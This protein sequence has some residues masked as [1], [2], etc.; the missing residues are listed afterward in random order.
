MRIAHSILMLGCAM[1]F[2]LPSSCRKK[3]PHPLRLSKIPLINT[4]SFQNLFSGSFFFLYILY[5]L[6]CI[7]LKLMS[8]GSA[9]FFFSRT[10]STPIVN[11]LKKNRL[12]EALTLLEKY[13]YAIDTT[14]VGRCHVV[15]DK[16]E[17][18]A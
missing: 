13:F 3:I 12:P 14:H 18:S 17:I 15:P 6:T 16:N 8:I 4:L 2:R 1:S 9:F 11:R 7:F 10:E 5:C